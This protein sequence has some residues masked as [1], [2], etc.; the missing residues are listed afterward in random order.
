M[1]LWRSP[2]RSRL[3]PPILLRRHMVEVGGGI[4]AFPGSVA[5]PELRIV[6]GQGSFSSLQNVRNGSTRVPPLAT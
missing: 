3:A 1:A 2:V 5:D 4:A 6:K